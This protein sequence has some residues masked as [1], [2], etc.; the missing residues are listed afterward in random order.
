MVWLSSKKATRLKARSSLF[1]I[2]L[3]VLLFAN[4][5]SAAGLQLV[6][7]SLKPSNAS[8]NETDVSY[9][10]NFT[11]ASD[12]SLGSIS[13]QFCSNSPDITDP[14][15]PPAGFDTS[16]ANLVAQLGAGGFSI[17]GSSAN[18]IILTRPPAAVAAG[19]VATYEFEGVTNPTAEGP[20]YARIQTYPTSDATGPA[21]DYGG[22]ALM[23]L[24]PANI[25]TEVPPYLL[26]CLGESITAFNCGTAT[27]P[28]SDVGILGPLVTGAAQSQMVIATNAQSGYTMWALGGTMTSGNNTLP[29]MSGGASQKG[30]SQFGINL[31]A[32]TAPII[33]QNASG[34]GVA[35]ITAGYNQQNQYR[36]QSGDPLVTTN[37]PDDFRK[38]TVSYI[39]NVAQGQPGGVYAT[40]LTY[41]V[42]ANF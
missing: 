29:A 8:A 21:T 25:T 33:G 22:L 27:E 10:L 37:A 15:T 31:R 16:D 35:G 28:F 20:L 2:L 13:L 26:F 34:P 3:T 17:L 32:N 9:E 39:V 38:F 5:Q 11:F 6:P 7:R 30:V 23:I 18:T 12:A 19:T 4:A 42:L 1:F 41:V 40:T 24:P 36:Y 14:C